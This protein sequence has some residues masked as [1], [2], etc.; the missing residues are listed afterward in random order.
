[1]LLLVNC[2]GH[3]SFLFLS[4]TSL[5]LV[6]SHY[7]YHVVFSV[8]WDVTIVTDV[9]SL[10]LSM[11]V[12]CACRYCSMFVSRCSYS[13]LVLANLLGIRLKFSSRKLQVKVNDILFVGFPVHMSSGNQTGSL[14][15]SPNKDGSI[16]ASFNTVFALNVSL[17]SNWFLAI[18]TKQRWFYH[19]FFQHCLRTKCISSILCC[20]E[21]CL[22]LNIN[23]SFCPLLNTVFILFTCLS[24]TT[25]SRFRNCHL[26]SDLL[27][28]PASC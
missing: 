2:Y 9:L 15:S 16:T 27:S 12:S 8:S 7:Q 17:Q 22:S 10:D 5:W 28:S 4:T 25:L 6:R 3:L 21:R 23:V 14:R 1:V 11:F 26:V 20:V 13:D 24:L 18:I 19:S